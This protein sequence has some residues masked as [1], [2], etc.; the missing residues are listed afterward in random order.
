MNKVTLPYSAVVHRSQGFCGLV[1][2][3]GCE[4]VRVVDLQKH[5]RRHLC[6]SCQDPHQESLAREWVA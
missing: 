1:E 3:R 4:D 2:I 5:L 6:T